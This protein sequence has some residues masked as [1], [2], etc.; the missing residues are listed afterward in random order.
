MGSPIIR[1]PPQSI[2]MGER[3]QEINQVAPQIS[4]PI[5]E[6]THMGV[7]KDTL[8]ED[9]STTAPPTQQQPLDRLNVTDERRM[10]DVRTNTSDVVVELTRDRT[11]T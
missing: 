7:I 4:H 5:S 9:L 11:R 10:N 1:M 8:Q 3:R 2:L 6:Q